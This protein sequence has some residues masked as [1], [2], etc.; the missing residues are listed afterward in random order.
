MTRQPVL[1][2]TALDR[3]VRLGGATLLREMVELYLAH[4]PERLHALDEGVAAGDPARVERAAHMLRSSAGNLGAV[5][6]QHTADA[7][8]ALSARG[9]LDRQMVKRLRREYEESAAL[10]RAALEELGS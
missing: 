10:L 6:L 4:G 3:L 9:L 1:E 5:R 8:E 2:Q 7:L